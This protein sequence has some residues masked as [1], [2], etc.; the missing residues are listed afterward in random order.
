MDD[1]LMTEQEAQE[2]A[3]EF[4]DFVVKNEK[5]LKK[6]LKKNITYDPYIFDDCFQ[7]AILKVHSAI[8]GTRKRIKDFEQYFFIASKFTYIGEDNKRKKEIANSDRDFLW[9]VTQPAREK[10]VQ[11]S[12]LKKYMEEWTV[13]AVPQI[14][15]QEERNQKI[16]ELMEYLQIKLE[17][18]FSMRDVDIF[19]IYYRL[20]SEKKGIS[21]A[22]LAKVLDIEEKEVKNVIGKI[23]EYVK[24]DDDIQNMKK[25]MLL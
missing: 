2:H 25:Y 20:K 19:L 5:Q 12:D 15:A 22:K 7:D 24:N 8:L 16:N 9:N 6:N 23:K 11:A 13:D 1:V 4:L 10:T 3:R 14:E 17:Q 21:Y 18:H